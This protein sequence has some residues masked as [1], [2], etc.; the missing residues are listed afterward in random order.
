MKPVGDET[1]GDST[2]HQ[3]RPDASPRRPGRFTPVRILAGF[4]EKAGA[5]ALPTDR[6]GGG[7]WQV[8]RHSGPQIGFCLLFVFA[9][10]WGQTFLLSVFQPAWMAAL[11]LGPG[12]MG[13]IYGGATLASGLALSLSGRWLDRTPARRLGTVT[14]LGLAACSLLAAGI[15][16]AATLAVALFGLRFFGQ[17][18]SSNVGITYAARW[19]THNRGKAIS[20]AGLGFPL[21][22]L[23]LPG[24]VTLAVVGWGWRWAW[25]ALGLLCLLA[26]LPLARALIARHPGADTDYEARDAAEEGDDSAR[27]RLLHDWRFFAMLGMVWPLPFVGTGV[28]FFQGLIAAERGWNAAVFPT[29]FMVFAIVRALCALSAG[30]WVDRLGAVRLLPVPALAFATGLACLLG[31]EPAWA[32]AFFTGMGVSF[33]ASGA[34]TTAAW[35]ELFGAARIGTI[36]ALSSSFAVFV[37]AAAPVAFGLAFGRGWPVA[38][39]VVVCAALLLGITWPLSVIVRRALRS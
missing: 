36:R 7:Y 19:F 2:G 8:A 35:T 13:A 32:Y 39:V 34:V 3:P 17:G 33:G 20:L 15:N 5:W 9:S 22:E 25:V 37:T 30:A 18:L 31:S 12:A 11:D 28:I 6:Q 14:L 26:I 1:P 16:H 23:F 10:S 27:H 4:W 29:G 21:G 24:L 38:T